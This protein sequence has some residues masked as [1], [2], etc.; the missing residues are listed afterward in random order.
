MSRQLKHLAGHRLYG[1]RWHRVARAMCRKDPCDLRSSLPF[2][3]AI[4]AGGAAFR[5]GIKWLHQRQ[6]T[7]VSGSRVVVLDLFAAYYVLLLACRP[8]K[9]FSR[10]FQLSSKFQTFPSV[11]G[12]N[13]SEYV[14]AQVL[15]PSLGGKGH[16]W[17]SIYPPIDS[18]AT[19]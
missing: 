2:P 12:S 16:R 18:Q 1:S 10:D 9:H 17:E 3:V 4:V 5:F 14:R 15:M 6:L 19:Q 13:P 7:L 11:C 8:L